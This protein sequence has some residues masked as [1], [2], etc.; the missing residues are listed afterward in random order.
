MVFAYSTPIFLLNHLF[1]YSLG[2]ARSKYLRNRDMDHVSKWSSTFKFLMVK[3]K[4]YNITRVPSAK[5]LKFLTVLG[6]VL[7]NSPITIRPADLPSIVM[8]KKTW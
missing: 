5:V 2:L 1:D 8:S 7:P 3:I 6:T 4:K